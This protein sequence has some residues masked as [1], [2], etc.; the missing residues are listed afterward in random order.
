MDG[1]MDGWMMCLCVVCFREVSWVQVESRP[2][3]ETGYCPDE[4]AGDNDSKA[5]IVVGQRPAEQEREHAA[6]E[7]EAEVIQPK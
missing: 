4:H 1:W 7:D 6:D 3:S 2:S 5:V